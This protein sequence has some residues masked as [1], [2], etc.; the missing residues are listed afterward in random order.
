MG[1]SYSA[2]YQNMVV[3][4][5]LAATH[6]FGSAQD[7]KAEKL[8]VMA[9]VF[10][11]AHI[12][13]WDAENDRLVTTPVSSAA[14]E[15]AWGIALELNK[16]RLLPSESWDLTRDTNDML[17]RCHAAMYAARK[18]GGGGGGGGETAANA[19][20]EEVEVERGMLPPSATET[21][22]ELILEAGR[23]IAEDFLAELQKPERMATVFPPP[24]PTKSIV[25]EIMINKPLQAYKD[26]MDK[27][28]PH[29]HAKTR[30]TGCRGFANMVHKELV[31]VSPLADRVMASI[32]SGTIDDATAK[33]T[34]GLKPYLAETAPDTQRVTDK[35]LQTVERAI[36]GA[37][38]RRAEAYVGA[39]KSVVIIVKSIVETVEPLVKK[40][41]EEA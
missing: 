13:G 28:V 24:P 30:A 14:V 20:K 5:M 9:V 19:K 37:Y 22:S 41:P 4:V 11:N 2:R 10:G 40:K 27:L 18:K 39:K 25:N 32:L 12:F 26:L 34:L 21:M 23:R 33:I 7:R 1:Q 3:D 38:D 36:K 15:E 8:A 6:G 35:F 16:R 29:M 17:A 31:R